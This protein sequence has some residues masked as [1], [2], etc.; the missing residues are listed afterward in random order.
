MDA[1]KSLKKYIGNGNVAKEK[2]EHTQRERERTLLTR[3]VPAKPLRPA[4]PRGG[5]N[6]QSSPTITVCNVKDQFPLF[7]FKQTIPYRVATEKRTRDADQILPLL[8]NLQISLPLQPNQNSDGPQ[9]N[10]VNAK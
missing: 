10:S 5:G 9:Y 3:M 8:Y 1:Y 7:L 2:G 6:A 4:M